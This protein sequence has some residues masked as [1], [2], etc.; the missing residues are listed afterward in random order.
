MA[1]ALIFT[2]THLADI[3]LLVLVTKYLFSVYDPALYMT[4]LQRG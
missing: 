4:W 1:F 2:V 3:A